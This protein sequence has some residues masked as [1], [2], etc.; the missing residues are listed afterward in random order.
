MRSESAATR[1]AVVIDVI[2]DAPA[3][4]AL[5]EWD[6][7]VRAAGRPSPFMLHAWLTQWWRHH[8]DLGRLTVIIGRRDGTLLGALPLF[9][10][11]G[12]VVSTVEFLGGDQS[13][14]GDVLLSPDAPAE[15]GDRLVQSLR[16]V[17]ADTLRL[18]G[19]P[20]QS[21]LRR[22]GADAGLTS[23]ERVASPILD[24]PDGWETA[25]RAK[26]TS[27]KRN[28]H[29]RRR[30]QLGEI[31]EVRV[32]VACD[33]E[34][35]APALE[36]AFALHQ[37][38]WSGRPDGSG[39]ATQRGMAFHRAALPRMA[40]LGVARIVTLRVDGRAVAFHYF[41]LFESGMYV[42]RLAFDPALA[43]YSPGLLNTLDAISAAANE[44]ARRV[45]YLGGDE[46]YKLELADRTEPMYEA[47][48]ARSVRGRIVSAST[49]TMINTRKRLKRHP[50]I[51]RAYF[52]GVAPARRA[53][54][55]WRGRR[56]P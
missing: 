52:E 30:R 39:F 42:H 46:R 10:R 7:L 36:E 17:D 38:R 34:D 33:I 9:V 43:Q 13:A 35:L 27:K 44:G 31:G 19:F 8:A 53:V 24:M 4:E 2:S 23:F 54:Q 32:E 37:L 51:R 40:D 5:A 6:T 41:F 50:A 14:L 20:V 12:R 55:R 11:R 45:E 18:F 48:G 49:L 3:F 47:I 1:D 22:A 15:L 28:H 29:A 16:L 56:S 21:P 25:Y 26:T